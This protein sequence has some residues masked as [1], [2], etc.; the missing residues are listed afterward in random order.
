MALSTVMASA[1]QVINPPSGVLDTSL[2][3]GNISGLSALLN[4]SS[5]GDN[6]TPASAEINTPPPPS[7]D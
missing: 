3:L 6:S 7:K 1:S 5:T 2:N 4:V